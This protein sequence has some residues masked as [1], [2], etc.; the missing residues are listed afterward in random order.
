LGTVPWHLSH[1]RNDPDPGGTQA[2]ERIGVVE[3]VVAGVA[4]R[5]RRPTLLGAMLLKAR[6]LPLHSRPE[7]QREDIIT[8]LGLVDDPDAVRPSLT[9]AERRWHPSIESKLALEDR[10][11]PARFSLARLRAAPRADPGRLTATS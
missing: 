11:L 3:I 8:L 10:A 1:R 5:V 7:D 2:L 6:A 4:S 9:H